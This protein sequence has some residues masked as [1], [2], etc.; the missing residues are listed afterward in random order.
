MQRNIK[1]P[2][3]KK[4]E[5]KRM[6]ER[7]KKK[8]KVTERDGWREKDS[9]KYIKDQQGEKNFEKKGKGKTKNQISTD[10]SERS[11]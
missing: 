9:V 1:L 8:Y 4:K 6:T 7:E 2:S 3:K 11:Q 10:G 5:R